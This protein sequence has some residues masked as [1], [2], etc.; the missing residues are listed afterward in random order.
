M[1][2]SS[3]PK[4]PRGGYRANAGRPKGAKAKKTILREKIAKELELQN[5]IAEDIRML[6]PMGIRKKGVAA[7]KELSKEEIEKEVNNRIGHHAHKLINAQ[8]SV[9]LGT[10]HLYRVKVKYD[11]AGNMKKEH[12]LIDDPEEIKMYLDDPSK[13]QG[14]DYIVITS[15]SPDNNAINSLMD[16]LVGKAS[17]KIVGANNPDGSEGPIKVIVANFSPQLPAQNNDNVTQPIVESIIQDEIDKDNE[18]T[19]GN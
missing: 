15:K 8:L 10:Q 1:A 4:D 6:L 18:N 7:L 17:T 3:L 14:H 9:A 11:R 13:V 5:Q 2:D 12:T 19:N 16:R